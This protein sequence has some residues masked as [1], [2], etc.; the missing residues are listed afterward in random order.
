M[1]SPSEEEEY[2]AYSVQ[3]DNEQ[4]DPAFFTRDERFVQ[5]IMQ[6]TP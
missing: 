6:K 3:H 1:K 4:I 2:T 5:V